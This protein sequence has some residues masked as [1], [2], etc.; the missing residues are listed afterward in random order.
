MNRA[1]LIHK[2]RSSD[3]AAV[4]LAAAAVCQGAQRISRHPSRWSSRLGYAL[5]RLD[6]ARDIRRARADRPGILTAREGARREIAV[7]LRTARRHE[8][9]REWAAA[10]TA[11]REMLDRDGTRHSWWYRLGWCLWQEGDQAGAV[12]ALTEAVRL[13]GATDP[14][15]RLALADLHERAG[16]WAQ[17]QRLLRDNAGRHPEHA[18]TQRRL[19]EVSLTLARWGGTLTGTLPHRSTATFLVSRPAVATARMA[20]ERAAKL[21]PAKTGWRPALAEARLADGDLPGTAALYQA[22]LRHAEAS[23]GR[24]V[25]AATQRW[26]FAL[27]STYHRLGRPRV[28]DPLFDCA[29][30]PGD[31]ARSTDRVAG[32]FEA[33]TT[34]GGLAISGIVVADNVDRVEIMLDGGPLRSLRVSRDG[35]LPRFHLE[36]KRTALASFPS[37]ATIRVHLPG[38]IPLLASGGTPQVHLSVPHG[39]GSLWNRI[40]SGARLDKKGTLSPSP[41]EATRRQARYLELYARARDFF[42]DRLQRPLFLLYG[43]LLGYHREGDFI[44]GDDDFDV[45]YLCDETDPVAVKKETKRLVIELVHAGFTVS[46]NRKGRLF[47]LHLGEPSG[48]SV[49]LDVRPVWFH[50]G[51]VW[52]HNHCTFAASRKDFL[53]AEEGK[54]QG[55]TVR[56]PGNTEKFL[57]GHYGPGWSVPDPGFMYYPSEIDQTTVDHLSRALISAKEYRDLAEQVRRRVRG[58][59][60]AG[61]LISIGSRDLYPLERFIP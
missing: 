9:D 11:Y 8:Q 35:D 23:T 48:D 46:F 12:T 53:P 43:T 32:L 26:Q 41:A 60:D 39:D 21:E 10:A 56:V 28:A 33:E 3:S 50:S 16:Q 59:P 7:R 24:W 31:P 40:A 1:R 5:E 45:G 2:V 47:R 22:A 44:A 13:G 57:R 4:W 58:S 37:E 6:G 52:L 30:R 27:E 51:R 17:A 54:L 14:Q 49:H 55:V 15:P 25:F 38:G 61:E 34:F 29:V 18:P 19:G 36:I 42:E 20:L